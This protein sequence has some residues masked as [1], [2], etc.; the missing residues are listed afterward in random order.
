MNVPDRTHATPPEP[1][2]RDV[3]ELVSTV[4][5]T[6]IVVLLLGS[7]IGASFPRE[8]PFAWAGLVDSLPAGTPVL[9]S[10]TVYPT[11]GLPRHTE[12]HGA[13]AVRRS[14]TEVAVYSP[15]CPHRGCRIDWNPRAR[16]FECPCDGSAFG[17]DGK[18]LRGPSLR[19]LDTLPVR[20]DSGELFVQWKR[21]QA[22]IARKAPVEEV[23][24]DLVG[25]GVAVR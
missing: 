3:P 19:G 9:L 22:G 15:L 16:R 17:P 1:P 20:I 24:G 7:I 12:V 8:N 4:I 10:F 11:D 18:L 21:F 5:G 2:R 23:P 14:A 13:W 6:L 25:T